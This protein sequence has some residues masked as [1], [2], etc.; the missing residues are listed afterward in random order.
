MGLPKPA[1]TGAGV[2]CSRASLAASERPV[3][4]GAAEAEAEPR[5]RKSRKSVT[6]KCL[7]GEA[8]RAP[9]AW[10]RGQRFRSGTAEWIAFREAYSP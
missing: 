4:L 3:P 6:R 7:P 1:G 8:R 2:V 10:A 9:W 5:S